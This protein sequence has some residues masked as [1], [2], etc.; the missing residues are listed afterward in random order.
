MAHH[1]NESAGD[2]QLPNE[3]QLPPEPLGRA[4][5][6][7][8]LPTGSP[9]D[10]SG[11][12]V[13]PSAVG[14]GADTI[15]PLPSARGSVP[16]TLL[17]ATPPAPQSAVET[18]PPPA[19]PSGAPAE[20]L[21]HEP[22][23]PDVLAERYRDRGPATRDS[24]VRR[25]DVPGYE[26]LGEL[27]RGGM[28]V[29]YK[30][31]QVR[32]NRTV[33]LKMIL[34]SAHVNDESLAR[35][36]R[37]AEAVAKVQ[38]PN[39]V[40]IYEIGDHDG[41]P[42]F[43][44]EF[45][46][47]GSLDRLV[48]GEPFPSRDVAGL[49]ETIARAMH[50][51][52]ERGIIHRDLKPANILLA[53][54]TTSSGAMLSA[55]R[56]HG[57]AP[58]QAWPPKAEA[59]APAATPPRAQAELSTIPEQPRTAPA[60]S[61][62]VRPD[63]RPSL[64]DFVPKITDFGLAKQ[65]EGDATA[66]RSGAVMGTPS[67]MAPEQAAGRTREIGPLA[68]VYALGAILYNLLTG[69]PPFRAES[70]MDTLRL[71]I[72]SDP[73][74]PR[75]LNPT[76]DRDLET[77]CLKCLEKD[78]QRRYP[79]ALDLASELLLYRT[80]MP[81]QA[82][83]ISAPARLWRQ[84]KRRPLVSSLAAL[85][86]L[87][88]LTGIAVSS[89]FAV[90]ATNRATLLLAANEAEQQAT[91]D[92]NLKRE[93]A[94]LA[95]EAESVAKNEAEAKEKETKQVL[96][97]LVL[98]FRKPD[99]NADG[100]KLTVVELFGQTVEQLDTLL[101]NQPLI[102]ARLLNA[103]GRTYRNLGLY[104]KS[105]TV[106]ERARDLHFRELGEDHEDTLRSMVDLTFAYRSAGRREEA[107]S[108]LEHTL[109]LQKTKLGP[110]HL[111]T[112]RSLGALG[113][114]Y[115]SAGRIAEAL[116]L[117]TRTLELLKA[118]LGPDHPET[119]AAMSNLA[120]AYKSAG[121]LPEA[122][123]LFEET[124]DLAR[125][126][127]GLEDVL[128]LA[129]M[130]NLGTAY[131]AAGKLADAVTLLEQTLELRK[132]KFGPEHP[133]TLLS[134]S[135][136]A[137]AYTSEGR[138]EKAWPLYEQ[139][140]E[141]MR[142]KLG[143][144]HEYTLKTVN[145][146]AMAY[147]SAGLMLVAEAENPSIVMKDDGELAGLLAVIGHKLLQHEQFPTAETCLRV[148]LKLAEKVWPDDWG[149]FNTKSMLGG[150]LAGQKKFQEAEPLLVEGYE[151]MKEREANIPPAAK[152]RLAEAIR[153]LVDLYTAWDRPEEVAKWQTILEESTEKP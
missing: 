47:G 42:F 27:G 20:T 19:P 23:P 3:T 123:L 83:P 115:L 98:S 105:V 125:N 33:A 36:Q 22:T 38:H 109:E 51:A 124:L 28:G 136:L 16:E 110:K 134:A 129:L 144:E 119:L 106:F 135:N 95:R 87:S 77:I 91:K 43:S 126:K 44:L 113:E 93:E 29:V 132:T 13:P 78:P 59:M 31:R 128:T 69:R 131:H 121:R 96:D 82:R 41:L 118:K 120:G 88:L 37:E 133:S 76:L 7:T 57:G 71:V 111:D 56:E 116:P 140:V 102:Q 50:F 79:S 54:S 17:S 67:Y 70:V 114:A 49:V 34:G 35:F 97:F 30:A 60:D 101:P 32:L 53:R 18:L 81:I 122:L 150:A 15:P 25:L 112:L 66:T 4:S 61:P 84:C 147:Q 130:N 143:P 6:E 9:V 149:V 40:Q 58:A 94:D 100:E 80:G 89:Y 39:I 138:L 148:S 85:L 137:S 103:I 55:L 21:S 2:D 48:S 45:V 104:E 146:L 46:E 151:G 8:L 74:S 64:A 63:S 107:L 141:L 99:P 68:D 5:I 117:V 14:H 86:V 12:L 10:D 139:T 145:G 52:H 152:T 127:L 108:L 24:D 65:L 75:L 90:K 92:A 26:L 62:S 11:P 1:E 73:I 153:R 72:E 142:A